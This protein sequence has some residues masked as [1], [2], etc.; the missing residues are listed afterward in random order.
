MNMD[1]LSAVLAMILTVSLATERCVAILKT[2][3]PWLDREKKKADGSTDLPADQLRRLVVQGVALAASWTV[4][5][6]MAGQGDFMPLGSVRAG[7]VDIAAPILGILGSGGSAFW[8]Q[9]VQIAGEM[10]KTAAVNRADATMQANAT[11]R[12]FGL[13]P[14]ADRRTR[15][16]AQLG[17]QGPERLDAAV[18]LP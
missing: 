5:A 15:L 2:A 16:R 18:A 11:A 10:K 14:S 3:V 9:L 13:V 7:G 8:A 6:F 17:A 12:S 1:D 4:A